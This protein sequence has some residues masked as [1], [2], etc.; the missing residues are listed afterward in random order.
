VGIGQA[1]KAFMFR[2]QIKSRTVV[3]LTKLD[4]FRGNRQSGSEVF[5]FRVLGHIGQRLLGDS[6]STLFPFCRHR[7]LISLQMKFCLQ[8]AAIGHA[9]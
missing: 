6:Q 5:C 1:V 8:A 4:F 7:W 3:N 2:M 9:L